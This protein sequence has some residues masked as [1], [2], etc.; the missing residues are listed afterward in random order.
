MKQNINKQIVNELLKDTI[1]LRTALYRIKQV[2]GATLEYNPNL[3]QDETGASGWWENAAETIRVW[4][5][6]D[7]LHVDTLYDNET[8]IQ[9]HA[10]LNLYLEAHLDIIL[11]QE[12]AHATSDK[13]LKKYI[14]AII[15]EQYPAVY[16][17]DRWQTTYDGALKDSWHFKPGYNYKEL[18][19]DSNWDSY[20]AEYYYDDH[21]VQIELAYDDNQYTYSLTIDISKN[22]HNYRYTQPLKDIKDIDAIFKDAHSDINEAS[23]AY[24][25]YAIQCMDEEEQE[26]E[27][28]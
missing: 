6:K 5:A 19:Y 7:Q 17:G 16:N 13:E 24:M 18:T 23:D 1:S 11:Q 15:E 10:Q 3:W 4:T 9:D 27:A 14:E 21:G 22:G 28:A 2:T 25:E 8:H 20:G 26:E 12:F